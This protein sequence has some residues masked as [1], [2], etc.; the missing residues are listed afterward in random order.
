M[1]D[2]VTPGT[3]TNTVTVTGTAPDPNPSNDQDDEPTTIINAG[4]LD[5][6]IV[7]SGPATVARGVDAR[8]HARHPQRRRGRGE[9]G[10][11]ER[12]AARSPGLTFLGT[13]AT[14]RRRFPCALGT[15]NPGD[16]RTIV[17]TYAVDLAY[18]GPDTIVNIVDGLDAD[19][20]SNL[21]NNTSQWTTRVLNATDADLSIVKLDS[22][23]ATVAG[24][25]LNYTLIVTNNGP[26]A[27]T[28]VAVNDTLPAGVT[29]VSSTISTGGSCS[30]TTTV[31]CPIGNL[32]VGG[33]ATIAMT[34]Q[35]PS[36]LPT[37]NPIVNTATVTSTTI[38]PEPSNDT[39]TQ[40]TTIVAQ[41][42][43]Q[44]TKGAPATVI[45]GN[46]LAYTITV[47]NNGPSDALARQRDR[48]HAGGARLHQQHG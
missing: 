7:K 38:D 9:L 16:M 46:Q 44:I 47:T 36:A 40:P 31:S 33:V 11:S 22:P 28:G 10:G 4:E 17:S 30:G 1:A 15:L 20:E 26:A 37:P 25:L 39:S 32:G 19:A 45:A 29:H 3:V 41:T 14:A 18:A 8:L 21:T 43:V 48:H 23:D 24:T 34:V 42:D 35:T 5:L 12:S 6:S 27:A 2:A 13:P